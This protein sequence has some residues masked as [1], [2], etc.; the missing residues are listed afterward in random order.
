MAEGS[1]YLTE[2]FSFK[3]TSISI[4]IE[5]LQNI[6]YHATGLNNSEDRPGLFMVADNNNICSLITGNY[7]ENSKIEALVK[8]I[9]HVNSLGDEAIEKLYLET[10]LLE[11]DA[12]KQ[13]AGLGFIDIRLKSKN[14]IEIEMGPGLNEKTFIIIKA[15]I[16]Y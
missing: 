7:I 10:L 12:N 13:G 9:D 1:M 2:K 3:K 11:Q 6:S 16:R 14:K 8:R 15:N 4:M 5:L